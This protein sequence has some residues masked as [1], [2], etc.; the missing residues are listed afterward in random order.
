MK[1]AII[2]GLAAAMLFTFTGCAKGYDARIN[3][4]GYGYD[5]Y[6]NDTRTYTKDHN[7]AG[8]EDVHKGT[9]HNSK[10]TNKAN[11]MNSTVT[12]PKY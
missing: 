3:Y 6:L 7:A 11:K 10:K 5:G 8:Y 4:P 2:L 9:Y 1:K 12:T